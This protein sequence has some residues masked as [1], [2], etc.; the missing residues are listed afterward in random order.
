MSLA[1]KK[2]RQYPAITGVVVDADQLKAILSD[3]REVSIPL[4]WF[5]KLLNADSTQRMKFEISPSGYGIYWPDLDEDISV[6]V[7]LD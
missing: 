5:P 3:G 7:F 1:A 4:S 6:K 2:V